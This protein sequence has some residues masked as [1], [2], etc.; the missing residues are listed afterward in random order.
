[1]QSIV[2]TGTPGTGKTKF[3]KALAKKLRYNYV[4]LNEFLLKTKC[5]EGFDYERRSYVINIGK[6]KSIVRK[7]FAT[8]C[9]IFD[10]HLSHL[11]IPKEFVKICFVLRT[12]PYVLE[13]RLLSRG[14]DRQKVLE[15]CSAEILDVILK[16]A[17]DEYGAE[18]ICELD[19]TTTTVNE[20]VSYAIKVIK[21]AEKPKIGIVNWLKLVQENGDLSYFFRN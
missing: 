9:F 7:K 21:G 3:S 15:N 4:D 17:I 18:N 5:Y 10:S 14:F 1:M 16:E 13:K 20:L 12:S 6:A 8:G 11:I 19:T 2:V